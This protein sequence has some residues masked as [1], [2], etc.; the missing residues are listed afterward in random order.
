MAYALCR[1]NLFVKQIFWERKQFFYNEMNGKSVKHS[2]ESKL[3]QMSPVSS[4]SKRRH[5]RSLKK[6]IP[7]REIWDVSTNETKFMQS[8]AWV[9]ISHSNNCLHYHH[10][11]DIFSDF[12]AGIMWK[13]PFLVDWIYVCRKRTSLLQEFPIIL[14]ISNVF[15][16]SCSIFRLA[17]RRKWKKE[18]LKVK[19]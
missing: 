16:P 13:C 2:I 8:F 14:T 5:M 17:K 12:S 9:H 10:G 18:F 7:S 4:P 3:K 19:G 1:M 15:P 6:K 11:N